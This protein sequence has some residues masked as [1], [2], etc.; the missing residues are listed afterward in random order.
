MEPIFNFF[1]Q[2]VGWLEDEIAF[3]EKGCPVAYL[4]GGAVF[5]AKNGHYLGQYEDGVFHDRLGCIVAFRRGVWWCPA[6]TKL[7]LTAPECARTPPSVHSRA[8]SGRTHL[9]AAP[10]HR[11]KPLLSRSSL[12]WE[13]F[14]TGCEAHCPWKTR[15]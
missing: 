11:A 1:A 7:E 8:V 12:D 3:S 9:P 15:R 6:L 4:A 13:R 2:T 5:A 10:P 14:V